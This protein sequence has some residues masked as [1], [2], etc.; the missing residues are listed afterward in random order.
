[1]PMSH[2]I[3]YGYTG[4]VL[5]LICGLTACSNLQLRPSSKKSYPPDRIAP[6]SHVSD[7]SPHI[8]KR[9]H[10]TEHERIKK[11][12]QYVFRL[13]ITPDPPKAQEETE[14]SLAVQLVDS[15]QPVMDLAV[16]CRAIMQDHLFIT[17]CE[18]PRQKDS[19][20]HYPMRVIYSTPGEWQTR[21]EVKTPEGKML[22]PVFNI[23]VK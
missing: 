17:R 3:K 11:I 14:I 2:V 18:K 10:V 21:F 19:V 9:A 5:V 22:E 7:P 16:G 1:M 12:D 13:Y 15:D 8:I 4:I 23:L 6:T 20:G